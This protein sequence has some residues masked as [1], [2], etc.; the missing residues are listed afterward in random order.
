MTTG[1]T[2]VLEGTA[3]E[4]EEL[5]TMW[6]AIALSA[7]GLAGIAGLRVNLRIRLDRETRSTDASYRDRAEALRQISRDIEKGRSASSGLY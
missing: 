4:G 1:V 3:L 2:L 5:T 6:T 7:L